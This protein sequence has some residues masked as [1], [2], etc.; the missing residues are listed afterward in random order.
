MTIEKIKKNLESNPLHYTNSIMIETHSKCNYAM[1]H[2][3]CPMHHVKERVTLPIDNIIGVL[4]ELGAYDFDGTFYPFNYSEPMIDPRMFWIVAMAKQIMPKI[5]V[6]TYTNGFMIDEQMIKEM[7]DVGFNRINIS[8][9][10][11]EE[12][13]FFRK[14]LKKFPNN[15]EVLRAIQ[16]WPMD[17]QMNDKVFWDKEINLKRSCPAP[18]KFITINSFGEVV[19]CCHDWQRKHV[20]GNIKEESLRHILTKPEVIEMY[21]NLI[22]GNRKPYWLCSRCNK[23]R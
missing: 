13:V 3:R 1:I 20:L 2:P 4:E 11:P 19:L 23:H 8:V 14:I 15:R 17:Q 6:V 18:Y 7:L 21:Y 10:T 9:Y 12:G 16:R 22:N 5:K